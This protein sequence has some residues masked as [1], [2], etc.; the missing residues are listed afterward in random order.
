MKKIVNY[1]RYIIGGFFILISIALFGESFFAGLFLLLFGVSLFPIIYT[2][3]NKFKKL[4]II[5]PIVLFI[6]FGIAIPGTPENTQDM[7]NTQETS[8]VAAQQDEVI[9]IQELKFEEATIEMDIKE[10]KSIKV[11]FNPENANENIDN[12]EFKSSNESIVKV[13][14]DK[15]NSKDNEIYVKIMPVGEGE[16]VIYAQVGNEIKSN[17]VSVKIVDNERIEKERAAEEQAKKEAEE[18]AKA[19]AAKAAQTTTSSAS[20]KSSTS[21]ASKTSGSSSQASSNKSNGQTV[22][23]TPTGKRYHYSP[24]CGGKNSSAT[25]LSNAKSRGLTPCQKCAK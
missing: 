7:Q 13:E 11:K 9:K 20:S 8:E 6:L 14:K 3:L 25:T 1:I 24:S 10:S 22:Y 15:E 21:S 19:E 4:S 17:E 16:C 23:V 5:A 12:I 2:K 18:K